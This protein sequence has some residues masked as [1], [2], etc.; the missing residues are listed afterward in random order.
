MD[1]KTLRLLKFIAKKPY[2]T[3]S[4]LEK[5]NGSPLETSLEYQRLFDDGVVYAP[6]NIDTPDNEI[7]LS[8]TPHGREIVESKQREKWH[9]FISYA[10]FVAA[11]L[12][13]LLKV[14][15]YL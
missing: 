14:V 11:L 1:N 7:R 15:D 6:S 8:A 5:F 3:Y 12:S 2:R 10:T 13:L 4:E 9:E